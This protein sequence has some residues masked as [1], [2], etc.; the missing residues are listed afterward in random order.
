[1]DFS[2]IEVSVSNARG[3]IV[4]NRP[5]KLNPLSTVTLNELVDAARFFDSRHDVKVVIVSGRGRFFLCRCRFG[6][7]LH[8]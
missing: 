2:T 7:V 8:G 5:D 3:V 4:L 1:M 6:C